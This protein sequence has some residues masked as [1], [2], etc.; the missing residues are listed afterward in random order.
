M[1]LGKI[2]RIYKGLKKIICDK[3]NLIRFGDYIKCFV[4]FE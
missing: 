1:D 3:W 4:L 2:K